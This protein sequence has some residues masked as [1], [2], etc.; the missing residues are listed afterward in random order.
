MRRGFPVTQVMRSERRASAEARQ[1]EYSEK[2]PT[3]QAKLDAL[4]A[5]GA[6]KQ[7]TRLQGLLKAEQ[8]RAEAA[9]VAA[10]VKAEKTQKTQ[11]K[12][13]KTQ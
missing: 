8:E 9:K 2:Y 1:K 12:K 6:T 7:R 3:L 11:T 4:P 5:T 13:G 10:S